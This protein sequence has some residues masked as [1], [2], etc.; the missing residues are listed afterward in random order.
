MNDVHIIWADNFS[1][2][3]RKT[4]I[5]LG[6]GSISLCLWSVWTIQKISIPGLSM[7]LIK[8][9]KDALIPASPLNLLSEDLISIAKT[10]F[11]AA[12]DNSKYSV[13]DSSLCVVWTITTIPPKKPAVT[14][15]PYYKHCS[16][17]PSLDVGSF[18]PL[19]LQQ[20]NPA[21]DIGLFSMVGEQNASI[22]LCDEPKYRIYKADVNL[23]NRVHKVS[24]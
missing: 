24:S 8:D 15:H 21:A 2:T 11:S 10:A 22:S 9:K 14:N 23:F 20:H 16:D 1:S 4:K 13:Y 3:H 19:D 17:E 12:V 5:E 7:S 6:V 18:Y